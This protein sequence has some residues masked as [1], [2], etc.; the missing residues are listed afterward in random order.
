[1]LALGQRQGLGVPHAQER[2]QAPLSGDVGTLAL[3]PPGSRKLP[4][5]TMSLPCAKHSQAAFC[6]GL[7]KSLLH[8]YGE[9]KLIAYEIVAKGRA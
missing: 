4:E 5:C 8:F 6:E 9:Q 2:S 3:R 1:M 7:L